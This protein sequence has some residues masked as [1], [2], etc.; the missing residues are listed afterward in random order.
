MCIIDPRY[1]QQA[2]FYSGN[3]SA[4]V[5]LRNSKS[6]V[7]SCFCFCVLVTWPNRGQRGEKEGEAARNRRGCLCCQ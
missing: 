5:R 3:D 2:A 4:S 7:V 1:V 6:C